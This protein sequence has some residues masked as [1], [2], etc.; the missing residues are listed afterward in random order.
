M[1][2][3]Q[4]QYQEENSEL[5]NASNKW[6]NCI[7]KSKYSYNFEWLGRKIIQIPQDII[8]LQEIIYKVSP[9]LI[10]ETGIAHG[11]SLVFSASMLCLLDILKGKN[12]YDSDTKVIGIE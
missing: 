1:T 3:N 12:P 8:A 4:N 10:I 5:I 7:A 6:L 9:T 11:G 2:S